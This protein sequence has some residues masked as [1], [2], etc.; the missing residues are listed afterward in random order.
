M[1]TGNRPLGL[2]FRQWSQSHIDSGKRKAKSKRGKWEEKKKDDSDLLRLHSIYYS[3]CF[4]LEIPMSIP[5]YA[6]QTYVTSD[7]PA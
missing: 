4:E 5:E 1:S 6:S 3:C 7:N 2:F